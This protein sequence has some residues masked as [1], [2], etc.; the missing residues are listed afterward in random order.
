VTQVQVNKC[1][2]SE[3][4]ALVAFG[5]NLPLGSVKPEASVASA[6][7]TLA[8][9][10]GA[11]LTYSRLW[12][13]PAYP[14]G[15]GPPFV[16]AAVAFAWQGTAHALLDLLHD[17]EAA[18][19]RRRTAR[20]EARK[21]DLDL[22]ALGDLV[23]PDLNTFSRWFDL[24][25]QKAATTTPEELIL[26]HPRMSERAFVLAPLAE[27]APDWR[28]PVLGLRVS[29]LLDQLPPGALDGL[30]PLDPQVA[31]KLKTS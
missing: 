30:T 21:M 29:E 11:D 22:L 25:P 28:H 17:V 20:W 3:K 10:A 9:Q 2:Q 26:P 7:E 15:S 14:E 27:V 23:L 24:T 6:I 16:N 5:A 19:G 13:T 8:G 31:V 12:Q 1:T 4:Q 18:F